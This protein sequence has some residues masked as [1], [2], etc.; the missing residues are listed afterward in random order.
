MNTEER[1]RPDARTERTKEKIHAAL[2][3]MV[4]E[5]DYSQ[6]TVSELT[7]RAGIHRKTFYI[8]Y[9]T[10]E[11]LFEELADRISGRVI[12]VLSA[13]MRESNNLNFMP[14]ISGFHAY[15][16]QDADYHRRLITC[17]SYAFV[18]DKIRK[19]SCDYL[20]S[21]IRFSEGLP[22]AQKKIIAAAVSSGVLS[23]LAQWLCLDGEPDTE[24]LNEVIDGLLSSGMKAFLI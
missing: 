7:A 6:I 2:R 1:K 13:N 3:E 17:A 16:R 5:M 10:I 11:A 8:H 4:L 12:E 21:N 9:E 14:L 18:F 23:A 24:E 22:E 19:R 20:F 15:I